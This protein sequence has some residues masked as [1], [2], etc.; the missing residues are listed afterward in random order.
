MDPQLNCPHYI[1]GRIE[2]DENIP[3]RL[4]KLPHETEEQYRS[5]V[6]GYATYKAYL[7]SHYNT[8]PKITG[9]PGF[10]LEIYS[11]E[12]SKKSDIESK[13]LE[14]VKNQTQ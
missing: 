12:Y 4:T 2:A 6:A 14:I 3:F 13:L 5:Y 1:N 11:T 7:D 10:A 8:V 9:W